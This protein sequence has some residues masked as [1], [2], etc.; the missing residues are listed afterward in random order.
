VG[1]KLFGRGST[2]DKGPVL[3]WI[4][5]IEAYQKNGIDLP[6]NL[7]FIFEGMEESGSEGL[8]DLVNSEKKKFLTVSLKRESECNHC[9][10]SCLIFIWRCGLGC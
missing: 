10:K 3:G 7:K 8:E 4:H 6:V 1:G 5:A 2:D 9:Q